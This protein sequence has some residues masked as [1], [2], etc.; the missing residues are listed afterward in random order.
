M[1][2]CVCYFADMTDFDW[3]N[4]AY[5]DCFLGILPARTSVASAFKGNQ[6]RNRRDRAQG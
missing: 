4:A 1:V 2:K 6:S 3:F 5:R